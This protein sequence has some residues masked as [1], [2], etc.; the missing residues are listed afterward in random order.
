MRALKLA[1]RHL[2]RDPRDERQVRQEGDGA[3][4]S[5]RCSNPAADKFARARCR[6]MIAAPKWSVEPGDEF[7][8]LWG[9]GYDAARAF[10]EVE[11]RGKIHQAYWTEAGPHAAI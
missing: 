11:H 1:R 2:P 4:I 5:S 10:I 6:T 8:M 9:T 7:T 3:G